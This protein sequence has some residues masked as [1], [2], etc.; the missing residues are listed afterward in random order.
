M[1]ISGTECSDA[2]MEK[3]NERSK[4]HLVTFF[5]RFDQQA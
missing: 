1:N 4:I 5:Q 3:K 2:Y